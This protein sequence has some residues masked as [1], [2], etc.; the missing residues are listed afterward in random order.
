MIQY[1]ALI[2]EAVNVMLTFPRRILSKFI[3]RSEL[4]GSA[5]EPFASYVKEGHMK[6]LPLSKSRNAFH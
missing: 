1:W 3:A 2:V 6:T 5:R 4:L